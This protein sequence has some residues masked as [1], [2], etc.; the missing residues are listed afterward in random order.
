VPRYLLHHHH[1]PRD[2]GPAFA[3]WKGFE[4][5]LRRHV[6]LGSCLE[7]GHSIW[8]TVEAVTEGDALALLPSFVAERTTLT[9]VGE[10]A[11]P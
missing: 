11:I 10:V 7:G 4:S 6:T 3:A 5:P 8:W 9:A 1:E 2:C